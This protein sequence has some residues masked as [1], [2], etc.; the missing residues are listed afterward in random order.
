MLDER[1]KTWRDRKV[2]K[3]KKQ[4]E[5]EGINKEIRFMKIHE[6]ERSVCKNV[7]Y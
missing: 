3:E 5:K 7:D 2:V 6:R 1:E 4:R